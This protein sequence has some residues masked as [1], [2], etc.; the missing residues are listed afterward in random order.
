[1][2]QIESPSFRQAESLRTRNMKSRVDAKETAVTTSMLQ[3]DLQSKG[4]PN[5][6]QA[7]GAEAGSRKV[8]GFRWSLVEQESG[9]QKKKPQQE[10]QKPR[11]EKRLPHLRE[12]FDGPTQ[13]N[14]PNLLK[15]GQHEYI[16]SDMAVIS[17]S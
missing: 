8:R 3:V 14:K 16:R 15:E 1:M 2:V 7:S 5:S 13:N 6:A 4:A 9:C 12:P 17:F 10:C 11:K